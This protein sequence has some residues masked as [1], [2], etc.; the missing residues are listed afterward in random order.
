M[1]TV[2]GRGYPLNVWLGAKYPYSIKHIYS[3]GSKGGANLIDYVFLFFLSH[4]VS[5]SHSMREHKH[6]RASGP[7]ASGHGLLPKG[8]FGLRACAQLSFAPPLFSDSDCICHLLSFCQSR[9][10]STI[11][12]CVC[13]G[14]RV[15]DYFLIRAKFPG[16][17]CVLIVHAHLYIG[18]YRARNS[19][20][21]WQAHF[22][23]AIQN[24]DTT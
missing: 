12:D 5:G 22:C 16:L 21:W 11:L 7:W 20:P 23:T 18:Q 9:A 24:F 13:L 14:L 10:A 6:P 19:W 15:K 2:R 3:G 4:F 8:D 1:N 17:W